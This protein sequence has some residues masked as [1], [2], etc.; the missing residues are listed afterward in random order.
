M[1]ELTQILAAIKENLN[2]SPTAFNTSNINSLPAIN[3]LYYKTKDD[4]SVANYRLQT[5]ITAEDFVSALGVEKQ[6]TD[7]LVCVGDEER[8]N[9]SIAVNGGGTLEDPA[10]SLPQIITYF[11]VIVRS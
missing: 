11:D 2:I 4:G 3:Y 6:L 8:Y 9:C 1:D 10:T 7:L 5:R